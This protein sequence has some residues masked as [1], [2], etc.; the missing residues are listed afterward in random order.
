MVGRRGVLH[1]PGGCWRTTRIGAR[2]RGARRPRA[3]RAPGGRTRGTR[4]RRRRPTPGSAGWRRGG[5]TR[6]TRARRTAAAGA[7]GWEERAGVKRRPDAEG[8]RAEEGRNE[9]H[10]VSEHTGGRHAT[11]AA[12][13]VS[14][15][16]NTPPARQITAAQSRA[17]PASHRRRKAQQA[18]LRKRMQKTATPPRASVIEQ[19][20]A[21]DHQRPLVAGDGRGDGRRQ[22][23]PPAAG[24]RAGSACRRGMRN[25]GEAGGE[26]RRV[27]RRAMR[28]RGTQRRL[29]EREETR[30]FDRS[31]VKRPCG[32]ERRR[33]QAK[34]RRG[35]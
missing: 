7:G 5:R 14:I 19:I 16:E 26:K 1:P 24:E 12:R 10:Q 6:R 8:K 9:R 13:I 32:R 33:R 20:G 27:A 17:Q 22:L 29:R 23:G 15:S 28:A 35:S 2:S 4:P 18:A 11:R 21:D 30:Y 34:R 3:P 25:R 31:G